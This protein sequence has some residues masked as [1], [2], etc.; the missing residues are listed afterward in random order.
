MKKLIHGKYFLITILLFALIRLHA[1]E[2]PVYQYYLLNPYLI[3]PALA[4]A[5]QQAEF[6]ATFSKQWIGI[7]GAPS[8]QTLAGHSGIGKGMGIGGYFYHDK[9]GLNS[10]TGL[11]ITGAYHIRLGENKEVLKIRR[12]S[13][14]LGVSGFQH[15]VD[16][17]GLTDHD[18]DPA[19]DGVEKSAFAV[20]FNVGT[21]FRYDGF[22]AGLSAAGLMNRKLK[23]YDDATEPDFPAYLFINSGYM[24]STGEKFL[25]EP[26]LMY[27]FNTNK[28]QQ[29]DLNLKAIYMQLAD[30]QYW[31]I[32]SLRRSLD[33]ENAQFLNMVILL[34]LNYRGF[35]FS[36][37][38]E[39]CLSKIRSA[40]SGSHQLMIGFR[41]GSSKKHCVS[42]PVF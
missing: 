15:R 1:Q 8:T 16:L 17:S 28:R 38:Y 37:A 27:Q 9:N 35:L 6:R 36:Y 39:I 2:L 29:I 42:C 24:F 33:A 32:L 14:G 18:Y 25:L 7:A 13:F 34:G 40:N 22:F 10:E 20:D 19:V 41:F 21:F 31:T 11:D 3:N 12:L 5:T 23:I 26:S 4:G 30:Q